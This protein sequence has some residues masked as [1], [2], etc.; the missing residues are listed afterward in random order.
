M[1]IGHARNAAVGDTLSNILD[2]AGYDVTREYYIN[3]AGNQITN[4]AHSIEARYDQAMGKETE[5]PA[6]GYY[7]KDIINI[8]KDLAEK[9]PELKDLPEDERLK[10]F[11][12]LGV[13]YEMEN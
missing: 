9:R 7:G 3:D 6:D 10:V 12:Q 4:L 8:G 13:D 1:H 2:A 5:L 11:R